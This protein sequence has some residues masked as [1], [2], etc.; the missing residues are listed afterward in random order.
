LYVCPFRHTRIHIVMAA[1]LL[2][3]PLLAARGG[4]G[5][6][7]A[8]HTGAC[9]SDVALPEECLSAPSQAVVWEGV[10][11]GL[12]V[13]AFQAKA[14]AKPY[15]SDTSMTRWPAA[16]DLVDPDET[17]LPRRVYTPPLPIGPNDASRARTHP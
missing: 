7:N 1:R 4:S 11:N 5:A 10:D 2:L 17:A 3:I 9:T 13:G 16:C 14:A 15:E 12:E 6:L 8:S